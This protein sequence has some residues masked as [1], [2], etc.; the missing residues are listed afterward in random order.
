[1]DTAARHVGEPRPYGVALMDVLVEVGTFAVPAWCP[2]DKRTTVITSSM[3]STA[4]GQ[5]ETGRGGRC[6][7]GGGAP[8]LNVTPSGSFC[9][10]WRMVP[11][12]R[13]SGFNGTPHAE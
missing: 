9:F 11:L 12:A 5:T 4:A 6:G 10:R 2:S 13:V 8:T 7:T 3:P 1:M